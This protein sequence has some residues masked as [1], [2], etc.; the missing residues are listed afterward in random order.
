MTEIQ[1]HLIILLATFMV[2]K[3]LRDSM[4]HDYAKWKQRFGIPDKWDFYFNPNISHKNKYSKV[5]WLSITPISDAWHTLSTLWQFYFVYV[6]MTQLG[7]WYGLAIG[8]G[9][10]FI[11]FNGIYNFM[12]YKPFIKL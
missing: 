9:G 1:K 6:L 5:F 11:V 2:Q 7:F 8:A 12:R 4:Q 10:V 3:A